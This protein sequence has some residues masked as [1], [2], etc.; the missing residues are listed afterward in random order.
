MFANLVLPVWEKANARDISSL[1]KF[2]VVA[3]AQ[4]AQ[5]I[6]AHLVASVVPKC[7]VC[8]C[9][10]IFVLGLWVKVVVL[11]R[12][13]A[14]YNFIFSWLEWRRVIQM[15]LETVQVTHR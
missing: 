3:S 10:I 7:W 15:A 4:L 12:L 14:E 11:S 1:V 6:F 9:L 13:V 8:A 2:G 5:D